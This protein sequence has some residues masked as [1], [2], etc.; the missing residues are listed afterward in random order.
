MEQTRHF[1]LRELQLAVKAR[2]DEAFPLPVW[3]AAEISELKVNYSGHCYL[4]LVEKG[5]SNGV[6]CAKASA[7]IWR[8]LYGRIDSCF[9]TATG[10]QLGVGMKVLLRV[11]VSYHEL[12]GF[13]LQIQDIDPNYTLGDWEQQR[14]QT[15]ARLQEEGVW[16][17]NREL[18]IPPV[19]QHVAVVSSANAAGYRDFRKELARSPYRIETEL[20]DAFMQGHGAEESI[21]EAL[22]RVAE[23]SDDFDIV[24]VIRGGG[25]QSDL[26]CFNSYRLCAH[27]AQFPLPVITG[28][29]HDKDESV[30]DMVAALELKTPTAVATW[31][32]D[33]LAAADALLDR[34]SDSLRVCC[35]AYL[36]SAR[37]RLE[38]DGAALAAQAVATTRR[39]ERTLGRMSGELSRL[40]VAMLAAETNRVL[41]AE[42]GIRLRSQLLLESQR[43]RLAALERMTAGH[44]P[45]RIM[46]LGFAVVSFGGHAVSDASQ[47]GIGDTVSIRLAKGELNAKI[48]DNGKD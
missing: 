19:P 40:S 13:S 26:A 16:D 14:R 47:L 34:E 38:R 44:D 35:K 31:I 1:S 24:V 48:T 25:S 6:P 7:V 32:V 43:E 9:R 10:R 3:V 29:G 33:R 41:R 5:G 46:A 23:R 27:L 17:M 21:V 8:S 20:F 11:T 28:I 12:Y 45:R 22:E 15:I 18:T 36:L 4:E 30:A 39:L 2:L 42:E 37:Q